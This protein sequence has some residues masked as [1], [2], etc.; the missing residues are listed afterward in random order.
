MAKPIK[1][2]TDNQCPGTHVD[3]RP[4]RIYGGIMDS[5]SN[6]NELFQQETKIFE[7]CKKHPSAA[8]AA[9]SGLI[10]IGT[11]LINFTIYYSD[12][13]NLKYWGWK[14]EEINWAPTSLFYS[15]IITLFLQIGAYY[16]RRQIA[17]TIEEEYEH[18]YL[19]WAKELSYKRRKKAL[20]ETKDEKYGNG[21]ITVSDLKH[22]LANDRKSFRRRF[23]WK[24]ILLFKNSIPGILLVFLGVFMLFA[25]LDDIQLW[26]R[27]LI[28]LVYTLLLSF[29]PIS[30]LV[31]TKRRFFR[32]FSEESDKKLRDL[33]YVLQVG[34]NKKE[35]SLSIAAKVRFLVSDRSLLGFFSYMLLYFLI[36]IVSI[37]L[38][39]GYSQKKKTRYLIHTDDSGTYMISYQNNGNAYLNKVLEY[40]E[41]ELVV[42]TCNKRV[43][44]MD[45]FKY[46]SKSFSKVV[47]YRFDN[48]DAH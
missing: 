1:P 42:D 15:F 34:Q 36:L 46:E 20:K 44:K 31:I 48:E 4:D 12:L 33:S 10:A 47:V 3:G 27:I 41:N 37:A 14:M 13:L 28:S 18:F 40:S 35:K 8:I 6:T 25:Q 29:G 11:F 7:Y 22:E 26:G 19:Y 38:L 21:T 2:G 5:T 30:L 16:T 45:D 32:R 23:L 24:S 9:I 43:V 39:N 17:F